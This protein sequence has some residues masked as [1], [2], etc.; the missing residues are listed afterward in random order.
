MNRFAW[1]LHYDDPVQTP[2]TFYYG[3]GPRG[4]LAL[5]GDYQ[6]R[7]TANGKSQMVP[8]HFVI[9][10]RIK[11][12]EAGMAKAF[13]LSVRVTERFSQLHQAINEIRETKSQIESLAQAFCR[14]RT[15]KTSARCR[16][17]FG[18]EN[19]GDRRETD[20]GEHEKI[21]R[22]SRLSESAERRILYL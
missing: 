19:V 7:L 22:Q 17:R 10:P 3:S 13:E 18:E 12:S 4:P 5:P 16:R 21:G 1:D 20:P 6:V 9:D 15:P 11:G 8:L 2:G 14:Q